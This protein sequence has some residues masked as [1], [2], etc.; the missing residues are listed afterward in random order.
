MNEE[1]Q[2]NAIMAEIKA[3]GR[4]MHEVQDEQLL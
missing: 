1:D 2:V 3:A 4:D